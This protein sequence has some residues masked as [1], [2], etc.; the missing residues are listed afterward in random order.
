MTTR[1]PTSAADFVRSINEHDPAAFIALF[2]DSAVVV[3][4]DVDRK[5]RGL[6]AI[7]AWS[8]KEIFTPL[9]TLDVIGV[10][11]HGDETIVTAKVD[12]E[13]DRTGLPDPLI[14]D[15]VIRAEGGRIASLTC[16]LTVERVDPSIRETRRSP[17]GEKCL[18]SMT[19]RPTRGPRAD[20]IGS[21]C[22]CN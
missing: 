10:A 22:E 17:R 9:V 4:V 15:N 21:R 18:L 5:V 16:R 14:M 6:D 7:K 2:A 13:F 11:V 8:E 20:S 3:D 12:G 1:L 19:D